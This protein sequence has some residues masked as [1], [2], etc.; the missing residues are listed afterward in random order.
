MTKELTKLVEKLV[1]DGWI[2]LPHV[3]PEAVA[4]IIED[5]LKTMSLRD[6]LSWLREIY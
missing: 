4:L 1:V 5:R 2:T 3:T 6:I